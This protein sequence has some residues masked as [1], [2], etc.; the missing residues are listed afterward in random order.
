M[1]NSSVI[2]LYGDVFDENGN[3]MSSTNNPNGHN[4]VLIR[5][6]PFSYRPLNDY[7]V[8]PDKEEVI[9]KI[10]MYYWNDL[11]YSSSLLK[12]NKFTIKRRG[13]D[14]T[15]DLATS[16]VTNEIFI[17]KEHDNIIRRGLHYKEYLRSSLYHEW[18]HLVQRKGCPV[19]YS[20][21]M[22][23]EHIDVY[24]KQFSKSDFKEKMDP[25]WIKGLYR[26]CVDELITPY[27]ITYPAKAQEW[28][29]KFK[30]LNLGL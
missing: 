16:C 15:G 2:P 13:K 6:L 25:E 5:T 11:G 26:T 27:G 9:N 20:T 4:L 22:Y 1:S 14:D 24:Y 8:S 21:K 30:A 19:N 10:F 3:P 17:Y 7:I 12:N 29:N 23:E 28:K 18:F